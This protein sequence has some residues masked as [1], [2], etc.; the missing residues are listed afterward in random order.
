[1]CQTAYLMNVLGFSGGSG[2]TEDRNQGFAH[3]RQTFCH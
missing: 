1:M 3:A 2:D